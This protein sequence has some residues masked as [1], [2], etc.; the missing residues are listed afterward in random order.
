MS[1][2]ITKISGLT[3]PSPTRFAADTLNLYSYAGSRLFSV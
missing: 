1:A 3:G 2:A